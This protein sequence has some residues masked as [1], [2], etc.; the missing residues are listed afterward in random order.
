MQSL[1][2]KALHNIEKQGTFNMSYEKK[3]N[4]TISIAIVR[5]VPENVDK[6]RVF[7]S[8]AVPRGSLCT[9]VAEFRLVARDGFLFILPRRAKVAC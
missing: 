3:K 1:K 5:Y 8:V 2:L 6:V 4:S 7:G 9:A